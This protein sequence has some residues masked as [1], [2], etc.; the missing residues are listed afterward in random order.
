MHSK[1]KSLWDGWRNQ[2]RKVRIKDGNCCALGWIDRQLIPSNRKNFSW[3]CDAKG[4]WLPY[5]KD[6]EEEQHGVSAIAMELYRRV[7]AYILRTQV[8]T[9]QYYIDNPVSLVAAANNG[10]LGF[11]LTPSDFRRIDRITQREKLA[12]TATTQS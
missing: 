2:V 5:W 1:L 10:S 3:D 11:Q 12:E 8:V 6:A 9:D 7:A 4:N